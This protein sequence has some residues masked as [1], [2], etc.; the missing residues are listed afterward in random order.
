MGGVFHKPLPHLLVTGSSPW[1]SAS[2]SISLIKAGP[3]FTLSAHS[4]PGPK[5]VTRLGWVGQGLGPRAKGAGLGHPLLW[6]GAPSPPAWARAE[7]SL[8]SGSQAVGGTVQGPDGLPS[9]PDPYPFP[10]PLTL[11]PSWGPGTQPGLAGAAATV[12]CI[13]QRAVEP[14]VGVGEGGA[15]GADGTRGVCVGGGRGLL[16]QERLGWEWV[17]FQG[18]AWGQV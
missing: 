10:P 5:P 7:T 12:Q 6:E 9:I 8:P 17:Q 15:G 13:G 16:A 1:P 2:S 14:D 18:L 3:A 11:V 4:A